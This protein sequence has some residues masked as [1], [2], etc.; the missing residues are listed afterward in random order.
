MASEYA[1]DSF[2]CARDGS[3]IAERQ[4]G[5]YQTGELDVSRVVVSS[6]CGQR[7]G[8]KPARVIVL[9]I[10]F[11]KVKSERTEARPGRIGQAQGMATPS[12]VRTLRRSTM[13]GLSGA[14]DI[15]CLR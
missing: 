5:G 2:C 12:W 15:A 11:V 14:M 4:G 10:E 6:D 9:V 3:G 7:V 1:Q 13:S 8:T